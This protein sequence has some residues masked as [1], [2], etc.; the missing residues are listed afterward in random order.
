LA[1]PDRRDRLTYFYPKVFNHYKPKNKRIKT[2][3]VL[4]YLWF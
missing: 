3:A 1:S 4:I 2:L